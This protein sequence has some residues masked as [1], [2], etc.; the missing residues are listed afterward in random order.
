[1][2]ATVLRMKV[3][4]VDA[5]LDRR[6]TG[7]SA[8]RLRGRTRILRPG[9]DL[10]EKVLERR[11]RAAQLANRPALARGQLEHV[12]AQI[13]AGPDRR[14]RPPVQRLRLDALD[15][16]D[17]PQ[18]RLQLAVAAAAD[19]DDRLG[20]PGETRPQIVRRPG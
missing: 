3:P 4:H 18:A 6:P 13:L 14:P 1:M 20:V 12:L 19:F 2:I 8:A 11:A 7:P 15:P 17:P 5:R 10:H 9:H 16:A